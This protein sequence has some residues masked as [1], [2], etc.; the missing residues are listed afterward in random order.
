MPD[1]RQAI[2][3]FFT[4][5]LEASKQNNV[6]TL[7]E[8]LAEDVVFLRP[9]R[10]P[11]IGIDAF[12]AEFTSMQGGAFDLKVQDRRVEE[13]QI[14]GNMAYAWT[15]MALAITPLAEGGTP[16]QVAGPILSVF[17]KKENGRWVLARDAN[18]L[19]PVP[20]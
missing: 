3:D 19:T 20:D 9:N 8:M 11:M 13:I 4:D 5:W 15:Y 7:R 17:R 12:A 1:D 2:L 18:M 16:K 6:S 14:E 10:P